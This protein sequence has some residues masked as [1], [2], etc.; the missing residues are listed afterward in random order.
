MNYYHYCK[1]DKL[2]FPCTYKDP[3]MVKAIC[4]NCGNGLTLGF[5]AFENLKTKIGLAQSEIGKGK[6]VYRELES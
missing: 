6:I 3:Q 4:P 2:Y 5:I 1:K